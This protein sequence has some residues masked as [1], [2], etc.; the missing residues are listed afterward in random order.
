M[1]KIKVYTVFKGTDKEFTGT[2]KEIAE[3]FNINYYTLINR[4]NKQNMNL[5]EAIDYKNIKTNKIY[6]VFENTDL[7]FKGSLTEIAKHFNISPSTLKNRITNMNL[8]L[9]K[10]IN[11]NDLKIIKYTVFKNTDKEFTGTIDEISINFNVK[12]D[13]LKNRMLKKNLSLEDALKWK[14]PRIKTIFKNTNREFTGNLKEIADRFNIN[15]GILNHR[16]NKLNMTIEEAIDYKSNIN[17]NYTV[18][19]GT[20]REFTGTKKEIAEHFNINYNTLIS[21]IRKGLS[22]EYIL[23][24]TKNKNKTYTVFLNTDKEFTG[25]KNQIAKHFNIKYNTLNQRLN[26]KMTLEEAI[27][28]EDDRFEKYTVFK[29]TNEEFTGNIKDITNHFNLNYANFMK[30]KYN[31]NLS[32]EEVIKYY[33]NKNNLN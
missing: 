22:I 32:I 7:E 10:A 16:I 23:N 29:G 31:S 27:E 30:F 19:E 8:S 33:Q 26:R 20:D 24:S 1:G 13:T 14:D 12:C 9:E 3:Y 4:I 5:E 6:T 18:F 21:N 28:Y 15:I 11:Y 17:E 2:K 25:T